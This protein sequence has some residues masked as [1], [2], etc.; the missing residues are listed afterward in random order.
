M[1]AGVRLPVKFCNMVNRRLMHKSAITLEKRVFL[2]LGILLSF[3]IVHKVCKFTFICSARIA[4]S[5]IVL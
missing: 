5:N 3:I 1:S 4:Y 2:C